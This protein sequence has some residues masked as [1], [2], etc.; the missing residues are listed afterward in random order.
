MKKAIAIVPVI[1]SLLAA[2]AAYG[3][4][5]YKFAD[6]TKN[7]YLGHISF[8]ELKGDVEDPVVIR[9]GA[10]KAETAVL[11]M[12]VGPGDTVRTPADRRCE[13]QFDSGTI[14]RLDVGTELR[15]ETILAKSL[16]SPLRISNLVLEYGRLYLMYKEY[17]GEE[18][19]Q[20]LTPNAALKMKHQTVAIVRAAADFSTDVQVKFGRVSVLLGADEKTSR[21]QDVSKSE[22]LII[23]ADHQIQMASYIVD[24]DFDR[25]NDEINKNFEALHKGQS[26]LPRPLTNLPEA[27]HYF[28][29]NFGNVNGEWLW[30]S[31][32]GYV[33]RPYLNDG[34][35]PWGGWQPYL[36]G[37]WSEYQGQMYWVPEETWGWIPYHLG[38]WNW[39]V[40]KG[41]VWIPGSFF[42]PAWADWE[43]F[44]GYYGWRPLSLWD[45][46]MYWG[47]GG[48]F[49]GYDGFG[50]GYYVGSDWRNDGPGGR[51][52][53]SRPVTVVRREE[54]KK[55]DHPAISFPKEIKDAAK[56][57]C[58]AYRKGD[59][60]V[61]KSL[62]GVPASLR[63][64]RRQDI[65]ARRIQ[66]KAVELKSVPRISGS[67]AGQGAPKAFP[68]PDPETMRS[69]RSFDMRQGSGRHPESIRTLGPTAFRDWNP[70]ITVARILGVRIQYAG[71]KNE[72]RC[73]ELKISSH[74]RSG[75][76]IGAPIMTSGGLRSFGAGGGDHSG[77]AS[78]GSSPGQGGS[79]SGP[80][81]S[82]GSGGAHSGGTK[83]N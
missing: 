75:R 33:W 8:V 20:V 21:R 1:L 58:A 79:Q 53:K 6:G 63:F 55:P 15:V 49:A 32:Y 16:S 25:W 7:F 41:W 80:R 40:K 14:I 78:S 36:Y 64:V 11:N 2:G 38:I 60:E 54:L 43:F 17:G 68:S 28:A 18:M 10:D 62:A 83:K 4:K 82:A 59:P 74:D 46:M 29:Q 26:R 57:L 35:Y 37:R 56:R 76:G 23:L 9:S 3:A 39:D 70:D 34:R 47:L 27:V 61:L 67:P 42:A 19:F 12:P 66:E 30:D 48:L 5:H 45:S 69:F 22:R 31:L 50:G 65:A 52:P 77:S 24:T 44:F 71:A 13:I 73:P 51:N 81:G 72:I